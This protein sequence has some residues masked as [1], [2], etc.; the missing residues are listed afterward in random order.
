MASK[1]SLDTEGVL[2]A[3]EEESQETRAGR[4][5]VIEL[6]RSVENHCDEA[7]SALETLETAIGTETDLGPLATDAVDTCSHV[8]SPVGPLQEAL[9]KLLVSPRPALV[10]PELTPDEVD[11]LLAEIGTAYTDLRSTVTS[12]EGSVSD[13]AGPSDLRR[14]A[15]VARGRLSEIET[16][17]SELR[18][19]VAEVF[20]PSH[21]DALEHAVTDSG[22]D[23]SGDDFGTEQLLSSEGVSSS[24]IEALETAVIEEL[25]PAIQLRDVR[26]ERT[27]I[28][29]LEDRIDPLGEVMASP[30][31]D[32]PMWTELA[33]LDQEYFLPGVGELSPESIGL[34]ETNSAVIESYMMG[35][36]HEFAETLRWRRYPTDM[37][38]SYFRQFWDARIDPDVDDS[39]PEAVADIQP[40]HEWDDELG[41]NGMGDDPE[42]IVL[43]VKGELLRRYPKT[44]I[45]AAKAKAAGEDDPNV[46]GEAD[47]VPAVPI[48]SVENEDEERV[49]PDFK[50]ELDPDV[51]FFGFDLTYEQALYQQDIGDKGPW[52]EE[53]EDENDAGWFFVIEEPPA[54]IRFGLQD[55]SEETDPL[56]EPGEYVSVDSPPENPPEWQT[57]GEEIRPD[58]EAGESV[59]NSA[60]MADITWRVPVRVAIH[61]SE[62]LPSDGGTN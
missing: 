10:S 31:I 48:T 55:P 5:R 53:N 61:A 35:L 19:H 41:G 60:H 23:E 59:H 18:G 49:F 4:K 6:L 38:G 26:I 39:D 7:R 36:N 13:G 32:R 37:R 42:S 40:L 22:V 43:L 9:G 24:G 56:A 50:G 25:D 14:R 57:H 62:M 33:D 51:T 44:I 29:E 15:D 3:L 47:R 52:D 28:E 45:Y 34:L 11:R 17:L 1:G 58:W 46:A 2:V 8:I 21:V 12:L 27:G 30:T 16:T 54:E 20:H